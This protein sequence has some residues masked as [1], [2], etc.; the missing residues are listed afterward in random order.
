MTY[1]VLLHAPTADALIR[2]RSN[3]KNLLAAAPDTECEIVVNAAGVAACLDA[4]DP[5]TDGLL[6]V[7][8]NTL[9][10][11]NLT[12]PDDLV[13][14]PAAVLYLVEKQ[15]EGWLYIRA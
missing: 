15:G 12:P 5:A 2:A 1:R 4:R 3:A 10:A 11:K 8:S 13:L 9:K 6:R 7:C 14:V